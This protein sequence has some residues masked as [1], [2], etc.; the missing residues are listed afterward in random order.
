MKLK[1]LMIGLL[2]LHNSYAMQDLTGLEDAQTIACE[3]LLDSGDDQ[4]NQEIYLD[5]FK[6]FIQIFP[7]DEYEDPQVFLANVLTFLKTVIEKHQ[8]K[9]YNGIFALSDELRLQKEPGMHIELE[10]I[11]GTDKAEQERWNT[12]LTAIIRLMH[13]NADVASTVFFIEG[14]IQVIPPVILPVT[15]ENLFKDDSCGNRFKFNFDL[16]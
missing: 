16:C 13:E 14:L 15:Q 8:L 3:L 1:F 4:I 5:S 9:N 7:T 10:L 2:F 11:A 6:E 12:M